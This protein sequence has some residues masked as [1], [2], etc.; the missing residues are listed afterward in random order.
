MCY[1]AQTL[2]VI[3][4]DGKERRAERII[5][6]LNADEFFVRLTRAKKG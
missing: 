1:P 5:G 3:G 4:P 2:R 6:K